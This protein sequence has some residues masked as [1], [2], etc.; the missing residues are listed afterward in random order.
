VQK[1][2]SFAEHDQGQQGQWRVGGRKRL[3]NKFNGTGYVVDA[4][5]KCIESNCST[6]LRHLLSR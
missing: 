4:M 2:P 3:Y 6:H 5:I 1:P